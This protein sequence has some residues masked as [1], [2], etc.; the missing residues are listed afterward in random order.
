[1]GTIKDMLN[2][3]KDFNNEIENISGKTIK[4][5]PDKNGMIDR[6]CPK[7]ECLAYFKIKYQDWINI[8]KDEKAFCPF[9]GNN[10]KA[11]DYM[12]IEQHNALKNSIQTAIMDNWKF[13]T[14]ISNN[15]ISLKSS[16]EFEL[17]IQ[18]E[19]CNVRFSVIG[20]AYFCPCCGFQSIENNARSSIEKII[21]MAEKI[22][23]IQ[24]AFE[25]IFTKDEAFICTKRT[26]ENLI[27]NCIGTLQNFSEIKYNKLSETKAPFNAF[28]NV[29]KANNLWIKLKGQGYDTWLKKDEYKLLI[30]YSQRRHLLEHKGGIVDSKYLSITNENNYSVGEKIVVKENDVVL[31]GHIVFKI[32]DS[33]NRL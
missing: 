20:A 17:H 18:C 8:V 23:S 6:Q 9:C 5:I 29:D 28:Q 4:I 32:I 10:S 12:P 1:M 33:I 21:L 13:G 15:I 24:Q 19:K 14:P 26:V 27:T 31:L 7:E 22:E 2:K 3:V 16:E 30:I 25:Q 11:K